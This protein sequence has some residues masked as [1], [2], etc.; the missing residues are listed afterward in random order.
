MISI[1]IPRRFRFPAF[2][3]VKVIGAKDI[4]GPGNGGIFGFSS[5]DL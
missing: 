1:K 2:R 5:A 3:S 4:M